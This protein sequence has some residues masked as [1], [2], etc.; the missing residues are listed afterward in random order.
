MIATSANQVLGW[1]IALLVAI[2]PLAHTTGLRNLLSFAAT[3]AIAV[4]LVRERRRP[5]LPLWVMTA[6]AALAA[7]SALWSSNA[8][9]TLHG[10]LYNI[11]LPA[12][13]FIAAWH[14]ALDQVAF[15][16]M[17][18]GAAA[19]V[20]C[21]G[22]IVFLVL[23]SGRPASTFMP[24]EAGLSRIYFWPG[25]G[26][27]STFAALITPLAFLMMVSARRAERYAGIAVLLAALAAAGVSQNRVVWPSFL[28]GGVAFVVWMWPILPPARRYIAGALLLAAAFGLLAGFQYATFER[29]TLPLDRDV[30]VQGW[31][32]WTAIALA[33]PVIGHG[34]GRTQVHL[35]GQRGIT[36][37]MKDRDPQL[38]SHAH[39]LFLDIVVQL[40]VIGLVVYCALLASLLREYWRLGGGAA[41]HTYRLVGA[42]AFS[43]LIVML[44]KNSTDDFMHQATGIAF[45]VYAGI[46]LGRL[47]DVGQDV[48]SRSSRSYPA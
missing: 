6:W 22:V 4:I 37:S 27:A 41:P 38:V 16:R 46:L 25:V 39:N 12:G 19:G 45:W 28:A 32:E 43:L 31:Q 24:D 21:L 26:V 30:R 17:R 2:L 23:A 10:V 5:P 42:A 48:S 44:A 47:E 3:L 34:F 33:R 15:D 40:G 7:A 9:A 14:A 1:L 35:E 8:A 29:R 11:V 13:V 20:L 36:Q 18:W